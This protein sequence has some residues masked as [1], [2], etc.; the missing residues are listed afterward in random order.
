[1]ERRLFAYVALFTIFVSCIF[2]SYNS[3]I[4]TDFTEDF[5]EGEVFLPENDHFD[6]R[7][8]L[9]NC[10]NAKNFT[11]KFISNGHTQF[12]DDTGNITVN[13]VEFDKMIQSKRDWN[14]HLFNH[15][16]E[17]PS[18]SVDGVMVHEIDFIFHDE[19]YSA[20]VKN[21]TKNTIIYLSTPSEQQTAD[22]V[23]SLSFKEE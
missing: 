6:F 2:V 18:W 22:I 8:F 10:S 11:V 4:A 20:Y 14:N 7:S 3:N 17:K 1:M 19:L 15:E 16:L 23:N 9:F 13:Y 21:S 12:I 5:K